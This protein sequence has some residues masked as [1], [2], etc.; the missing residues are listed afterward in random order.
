MSE[1]KYP[2]LQGDAW[3]HTRDALHAYARLMGKYRA[4]LAPKQKHWWHV[5]LIPSLK[6]YSTGLLHLKDEVISIELNLITSS[7][8]MNFQHGSQTSIPLTGQSNQALLLSLQEQLNPFGVG[9]IDQNV[10]NDATYAGYSRQK[11]IDFAQVTSGINSAFEIFK[12]EQRRET[13]PVTLWAH[14]FDL[15]MLWFSGSLVDG[16][17][18]ADE[19]NADEQVNFGFSVG[20]EVIREPYFYI[21]AYPNLTG[22]E[23]VELPEGSVWQSEGW[24]G[25]LMPYAVLT[26]I[27]NPQSH[28]L[29]FWRSFLGKAEE[30]MK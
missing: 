27:E 1:Q 7:V 20:D 26:E 23:K 25:A 6:G 9:S 17:D 22:L 5:G 15:A 30:L 18:P 12:A 16:V 21:T 4:L 28:L 8:D 24:N 2:S 29:S 14:H 10:V 13:G 19:E 3:I 11:T